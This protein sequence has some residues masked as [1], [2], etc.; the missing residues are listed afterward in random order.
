M[1]QIRRQRF[2]I[3][4]KDSTPTTMVIVLLGTTP[5]FSVEIAPPMAL[6]SKGK[7]MTTPDGGTLKQP[8]NVYDSFCAQHG[9][10]YCPTLGKCYDPLTQDCRVAGY[11]APSGLPSC[12]RG[13]QARC[14]S[15]YSGPAGEACA[16]GAVQSQRA[17]SLASPEDI[18]T[19]L[20]LP[21]PFAW[22]SAL[23][24]QLCSH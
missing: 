18:R 19:I 17:P 2:K 4:R 7:K 6:S 23:A 24:A 5:F 1:S 11:T 3:T 15:V 14:E 9:S 21:Q 16:L 13:A 12:V 8:T 22:G 10:A 20:L